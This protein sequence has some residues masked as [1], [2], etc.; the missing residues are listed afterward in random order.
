M[1][2]GR[3]PAAAEAAAREGDDGA[4]H[5]KG[6]ARGAVAAEEERIERGVRSPECPQ[7][8]L[9]S[10]VPPQEHH[11]PGPRPRI[12]QPHPHD[13]PGGLSIAVASSSFLHHHH[14]HHF[15]FFFFR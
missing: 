7:Q 8:L 13:R 3:G 10:E 2:E 11:R 14:H 6:L 9:V 5:L 15:F 1:V 12:L 4:A